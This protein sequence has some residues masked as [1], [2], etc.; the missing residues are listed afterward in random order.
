[1][2]TNT[3]M[4]KIVSISILI[5]GVYMNTFGQQDPQNSQ[6]MFNKFIYNPGYAGNSGGICAGATARQQ[7]V[8]F[9]GAPSTTVFYADAAINPFNISSGVGLSISND[10]L[11]FEKNLSIAG[12]YAYRLDLG[13]GML[14]I[15]ANFG[16]YNKALDP[17]W[18]IPNGDY[19]TQ[20]SG[21]PLIP[22]NKESYVAFD[23]GL[24]VFFSTDNFYVGISSTH[25]NQPNIKF[26]KGTPFLAR[27]Y[28]LMGG[29]DL[30]L[31]NPILELLPSFFVQ[32]DGKATQLT[33]NTTLLYNKKIWG[34]VSYRT[35]DAFTGLIGLQ[36][37]NGLKIG[38]SYDFPTSDIRKYSGGT[39][40]L[41]IKYCFNVSLQHVPKRYKSIRFL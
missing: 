16:L 41:M 31:P 36:L 5:I 32:S 12:T 25:I 11:G 22:E 38:Y 17:T 39:H 14:G 28:Y 18:K 15:G 21:D 35:G 30:H 34:G 4:K 33:I 13:K 10:K 8:G 20:P 23:L 19:F 27:H 1:M 2:L 24:G 6:Y 7:W 29:Y 9:E 40:E 37:I 3:R 26:N